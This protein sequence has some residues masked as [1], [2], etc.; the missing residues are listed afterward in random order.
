MGLPPPHSLTQLSMPRSVTM[1]PVADLSPRPAAAR[2]CGSGA[3]AILAGVFASGLA[4]ALQAQSLPDTGQDT[5]YD[6][7]SMVTCANANTGETATWP[8]QDGRIG[9]DP[10]AA[11]GALNKTGDGAKGF[12]YTKLDAAGNPLAIQHTAWATSGGYDSGSEGAGTKWSCVRDNITGL[13][14]ETKTHDATPGLREMNNT[15]TWYNTNGGTNGGNAGNIGGNNCNS[16]LSA[17][18]NQCNTQNYVAAVNASNLC[19]HNDWRLPS[20]RELITLVHLGS[21]NPAIDSS[22][23]PNTRSIGYWTRGTYAG[24]ARSAWYAYFV[25][26]GLGANYKYSYYAVRLV[27]GGQF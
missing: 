23:F 15:Y 20:E 25:D 18:G 10:A 9:R 12:D 17:Y 19:G 13:I 1:N 8:R 3:A 7:S 6:G 5:C 27:R 24:D 14:W 16:T 22:Y 11:Q 4:F 2:G 21:S 26:G